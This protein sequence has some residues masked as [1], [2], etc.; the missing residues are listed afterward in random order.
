[1]IAE[2][3]KARD[4][5]RQCTSPSFHEQHS[6]ATAPSPALHDSSSTKLELHAFP[7][8]TRP[9]TSWMRPVTSDRLPVIDVDLQS[10]G[11]KCGLPGIART[12]RPCDQLALGTMWRLGEL[13]HKQ[14]KACPKQRISSCP[15]QLM[16]H[17]SCKA[18][19]AQAAALSDVCRS[20]AHTLTGQQQAGGG[21]TAGLR[22]N[23]MATVRESDDVDTVETKGIGAV[24]ADDEQ[25]VATTPLQQG[26]SPCPV[27]CSDSHSS[28][29]ESSIPARPR[30]GMIVNIEPP[31]ND[32]CF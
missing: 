4:I 1:M 7:H 6:K 21:S 14:P 19:S 9:G 25:Q 17:H 26:L 24:T 8:V 22:V 27:N 3:V 10:A 28:Q 12:P 23:T 16:S 11:Q 20:P 13:T 18:A 31:H 32:M 15:A 2:H 29:G 30:E 5:A